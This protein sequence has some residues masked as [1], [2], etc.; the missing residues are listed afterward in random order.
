[1][2]D[3]HK[4]KRFIFEYRI[5]ESRQQIKFLHSNLLPIITYLVNFS[6]PTLT[7]FLLVR[8]FIGNFFYQ[9]E[10]KLH[11]DMSLLAG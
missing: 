2:L 3:R 7:N 1:M 8:K 4:V 9:M 11:N 10:C 5:I 6:I